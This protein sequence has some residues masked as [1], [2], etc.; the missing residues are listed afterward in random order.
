MSDLVIDSSIAL[1]IGLD[2]ED[3]PVVERLL[4]S[5]GV[6]DRFW[7]PPLFW[8]EVANGLEMARRRG[9]LSEA[10]TTET[11]NAIDRLPLMTD[12]L[13]G[14]RA[15]Q[16]HRRMAAQY[17]LTAYDACYLELAERRVLGLATLD[18]QLARAAACCGVEVYAAD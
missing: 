3:S 4:G 15:T 2:D 7:I 1:A 14:V 5:L 8:S 9:R 11:L 13:L 12:W 10:R 16:S 17:D 18:A 6:D